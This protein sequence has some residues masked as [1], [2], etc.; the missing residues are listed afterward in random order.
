VVSFADGHA[1]Q[2]HWREPTTSHFKSYNQQTHKGDLDLERF[3][4]ATYQAPPK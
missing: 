4:Q 2:W 3:R 1:D